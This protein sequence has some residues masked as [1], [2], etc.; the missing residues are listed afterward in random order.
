MEAVLPDGRRAGPVAI[1]ARPDAL[2]AAAR[3]RGFFSYAAGVAAEMTARYGVGGV[4]IRVKR[5]DLPVGK[6]LSS[7]AAACVLVARAFGVAWD[8]GLGPARRDGARLR[9]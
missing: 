7:S 5:T 6:G 9:R 1:P 3:A 2:D 8:L 4:R